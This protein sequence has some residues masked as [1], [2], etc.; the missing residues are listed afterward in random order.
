MELSIREKIEVYSQLLSCST[1]IYYWMCDPSLQVLYSTC[2]NSS[3]VF[4]LL[5]ISDCHNYLEDYI[6]QNSTQ[7]LI[8]SDSLGISWIACFE[9]EKD[10]IARIHL[11][12]P[13]FHSEITSRQIETSLANKQYPQELTRE[14]IRQIH[15]FPVTPLTTWLQYGQMLHYCVWGE[16]LEISDFY[17]QNSDHSTLQHTSVS[18][19]A[20]KDISYLAEQNAMRM[21]EE[22]CMDYKTTYGHLT[23]GAPAH[24]TF[25]DGKISS[26]SLITLATRAAIRGGLDV[27][28]AFYVGE[29]YIDN[30]K[31]ISNLSDL[32]QLTTTMFEDFIQRVHK[33]KLQSG[34]SSVTQQLCNHI[35]LH[36][37]EKLSLSQ[38]ADEY[39]YAKPYLAQKFKREMGIT[40]TDYV[41]QKKIE[42]A[43]QLLGSTNQSISDISDSL[44][45]C[46]PS[47][48]IETFRKTTG[49]T[50]LEFRSQG[51]IS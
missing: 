24:M 25:E 23:I 30:I 34:I 4:S 17:H 26:I 1:D 49:K 42:R 44:G 10:V 28:T 21:I 2:P 16:K 20:R 39:G 29:Y 6:H 41:K 43:R 14:F 33:V 35:E 46:N 12:G 7:T 36:L 48:F 8:L 9:L 50:P 3:M 45:Y 22:G 32:M 51:G 47:Y 15:L 40:F 13:T 37:G 11:I 5:S 38:L 19:N 18:D 31:K 27:E